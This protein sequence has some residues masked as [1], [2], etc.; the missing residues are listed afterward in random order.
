MIFSRYMPFVHFVELHE[1]WFEDGSGMGDGR[2]VIRERSRRTTLNLI[3]PSS[4]STGSQYWRQCGRHVD[5][6]YRDSGASQATTAL[7]GDFADRGEG[8]NW[9]GVPGMLHHA[10]FRCVTVSDTYATMNL[11][12]QTHP[13]TVTAA[14]TGGNGVQWVD[15]SATPQ[16]LGSIES[17]SVTG[18]YSP[19]GVDATN[20]D[21]PTFMCAAAGTPQ[22]A[23]VYWAFVDYQHSGA[24]TIQVY[25]RGCRNECDE[26]GVAACPNYSGPPPPETG[27]T[28]Y[29]FRGFICDH[30][31]AGDFGR[32]ECGCGLNYSG[33]ATGCAM[34]CSSGVAIEGDEQV[35]TSTG[36]SALNRDDGSS[37]RRWMCLVPTLSAG[38]GPVSGGPGY[39]LFRASVPFSAAQSTDG[40]TLSG[41][42]FVVR[43]RIL[44]EVKPVPSP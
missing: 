18:S 13:T 42:G 11:S 2:Y 9:S 14:T 25:R 20:P 19:S 44:R 40:A 28:R 37:S 33:L 22:N 43:S 15:N 16:R 17:C 39:R 29:N 23:Q 35:F 24:G 32:I 1:G 38:T 31:A 10:Q 26:D 30:D 36:L 41:G 7:G 3:D 6:L 12:A 8:P 27:L 5:R 4:P 21:Q 34:G